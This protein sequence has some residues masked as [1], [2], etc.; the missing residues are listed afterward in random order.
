[1][2][3]Q[4]LYNAQG[5]CWFQ[6]IKSNQTKEIAVQSLADCL[7]NQVETL[8]AKHKNIDKTELGQKTN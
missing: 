6:E 7:A 1:M 4:L 8:L 2:H 5:T 3:T